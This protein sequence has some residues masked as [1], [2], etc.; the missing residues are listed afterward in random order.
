MRRCWRN[1]S[2]AA[3]DDAPRRCAPTKTSASKR[4]ARTQTRGPPQRHR[5]SHGR[6]RGVPAQHCAPRHARHRP[7]AAATTGSIDGSRSDAFPYIEAGGLR[8]ISMIHRRAQ[9]WQSSRR[10]T[11]A[12]DPV[13]GMTVDPHKTPHRHTHQGRPYYF[14]SAGC[15]TKFA[16]DPAK[17]L[18]PHAHDAG[19]GA[20]RH[21]LH[22]PHASG[23]APDR[24]RRLPDLRHGA[25]AG[26]RHR[27]HRTQSRAR[28]H[29]AAVLD[30]A[31]ADRAGV[32]PGDG[33]DICS[34]RMAGSARRC[35]TGCNSSSPR[36]WCCGPAGRSSS[37]AGSRSSPAISTCSR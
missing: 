21:G 20:G 14:C 13:C 32:R 33:R 7:A 6:C 8:I 28:R 34:A 3:R 29:D 10:P 23:G 19:A 12:I 1:A 11:G 35:R 4:T 25:G 18:S 26:A 37:A 24:A 31:R 27:G 36:R 22:L 16:A 2:R 17:Y 15:R 5:L 30:R 9:R